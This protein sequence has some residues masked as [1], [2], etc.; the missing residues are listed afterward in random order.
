MRMWRY[1]ILQ[2]AILHS[3]VRLER[4]EHSTNPNNTVNKPVK[5]VITFYHMYNRETKNTCEQYTA[6]MTLAFLHHF[7]FHLFL[8]LLT[9]LSQLR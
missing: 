3:Q 8:N 2:M 6:P 9:A 7:D 5:S 1:K 4:P